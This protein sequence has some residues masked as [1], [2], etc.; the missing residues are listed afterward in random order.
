MA[1]GCPGQENS[2]RDFTD[3]AD[4]ISDGGSNKKIKAVK[5]LNLFVFSEMFLL[6]YSSYPW[7]NEGKDY[8]AVSMF[9][10]LG[11]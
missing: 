11:I 1:F 3:G 2:A 9:M 4:L 10:D 8:A 5:E 7:K 6:F